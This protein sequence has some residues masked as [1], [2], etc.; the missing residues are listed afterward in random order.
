MGG[1]K[2]QL[3]SDKAALL[4]ALTEWDDILFQSAFALDQYDKRGK[5]KL[6][7]LGERD[8]DGKKME[9]IVASYGGSDKTTFYFDKDSGMLKGIA[10]PLGTEEMRISMGDYGDADGVY[11]FPTSRKIYLGDKK[12]A[13]LNTSFVSVNRGL[14]FPM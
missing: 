9:T 7:Y 14:F 8:F 2:T 6:D 13:E 5:P 4:R 12:I 10:F 11:R 1:K 3:E